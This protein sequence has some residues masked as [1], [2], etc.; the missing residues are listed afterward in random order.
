MD[1]FSFGLIL[2]FLE[3]G[4][5]YWDG[6]NEEKK[7]EI[8]STKYLPLQLTNTSNN[9]FEPDDEIIEEGLRAKLT[10][11]V[12]ENYHY[13][14]F[15]VLDKNFMLYS[16]S[17]QNSISNYNEFN[18]FYKKSLIDLLEYIF[19]ILCEVHLYNRFLWII[20]RYCAVK[21]RVVTIQ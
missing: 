21:D 9:K 5:H 10:Q 18:G 14:L 6:E 11:E 2:Y 15:N 1:M 8:I 13:E 7:E 19:K 3:I 4:H 16:I 20:V 12:Q 17:C